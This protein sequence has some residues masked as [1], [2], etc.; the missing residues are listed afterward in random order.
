MSIKSFYKKGNSPVSSID[1]NWVFEANSFSET[2]SYED[3]VLSVMTVN[4]FTGEISDFSV[5]D[6]SNNK[7]MDSETV[8]E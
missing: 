6:K 8:T 2:I 5:R 7:N 4:D 3:K 1:K